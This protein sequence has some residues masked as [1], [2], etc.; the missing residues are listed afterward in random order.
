VPAGMRDI[1]RD[2]ASGN[3]LGKNMPPE[4]LILR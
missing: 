3:R 1:I 2:K 4:G